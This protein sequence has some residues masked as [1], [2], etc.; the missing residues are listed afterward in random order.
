L[1]QSELLACERKGNHDRLLP[2]PIPL[3]KGTP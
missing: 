1:R 2:E 3:G